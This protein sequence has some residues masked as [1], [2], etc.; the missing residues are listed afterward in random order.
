MRHAIASAALTFAFGFSGL[1][2]QPGYKPYMEGYK[3][4]EGYKP[5][6]SVPGY[7]PYVS[8]PGYKPGY[9][10]YG[11]KPV[12]V[13]KEKYV[14][15]PTVISHPFKKA[16]CLDNPWELAALAGGPLT[17]CMIPYPYVPGDSFGG[18]LGES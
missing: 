4:V 7:K 10:P 9:K 11:F 14:T 5:Y 16:S 1:I 12:T 17:F 6:V 8:I 18:P 2:T 13:T 15:P 3:P